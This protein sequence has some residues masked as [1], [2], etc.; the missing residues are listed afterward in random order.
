MD[1]AHYMQAEACALCGS[2]TKAFRERYFYPGEVP[3]DPRF[4]V[5]FQLRGQHAT[6]C[7]ECLRAAITQGPRP[8]VNTGR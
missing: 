8:F 3:G 7:D 1:G 6:A 2:A 4:T 5:T